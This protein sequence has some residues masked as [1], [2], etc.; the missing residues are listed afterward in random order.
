MKN[1]IVVVLKAMHPRCTVEAYINV[2]AET[3]AESG[4]ASDTKDDGTQGAKIIL[5]LGGLQQLDRGC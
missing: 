3:D 2:E 1:Y 5:G 4:A